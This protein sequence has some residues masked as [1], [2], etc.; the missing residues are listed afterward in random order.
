M[1]K[2]VDLQAINTIRALSIDA[3]EAAN[4]GHPGLPMGA[5]PMA[6]VLWS[7]FLKVNPLTNKSW[8]NRDRF[9]LSAGHGSAM[10]YSLLHLSGY[11]VTLNDLRN[12]R[13]VNSKTPGHPE[14]NHTEGVEATT[15]P[16]GQGVAMAVGMAMAESHLA[17]TYNKPNYPIVDH[18]TY[19]MCGDGDLME[20]V[21]QEACSLAGHLGLGKLI[22]LYDSNDISLD[23]P[24]HK[25][26]TEDTRGKFIAYGWQHLLVEDGNDLDAIYDAINKAKDETDK[27][28]LIEVKTIIGYGASN[29]GTAKVHGAPL[30]DSEAKRVKLLYELNA[31]ESFYVSEDVKKHFHDQMISSGEKA[32]QDWQTL[33]ND[34]EIAY[35]ELSMQYKNAYNNQLP[36]KYEEKLPVFQKG[37]NSASRVTSSEIIQSLAEMI[38]QLW[39]GSADLSSSNHTMIK[40]ADDYTRQSYH[41]RNIWFGVR[42]FAMAAAANGIQLHGGTKVFCGT[43]FVFVDYLKAAIRLSALQKIPTIYVLTHDSIAV[44]EDGPTHEPI[45]QLASLRSIPNVNV[46]RP[47]DANE[48]LFAWKLAIESEHTPTVLVLSRQNLPLIEAKKELIEEGVSKGGYVIS[49]QQGNEPEGILIATGSE[50]SL[51]IEAQ[52]VLS[53]EG[54]DVSVVSLPSFERFNQQPTEYKAHVLPPH[55]EKRVAIEM[56]SSYG[57]HQFVGLKGKICSI[58]SFGASG[59][60]PEIVKMYGFTVD[61]IVHAFKSIG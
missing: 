24:T 40:H 42:E 57:W 59:P 38:P 28:T 19:S 43:F 49:K 8:H 3:V 11:N 58:D 52:N 35:P 1:F 2:R 39:G 33:F 60:G 29:Q 50:V 37:Y 30:G 54:I 15:G 7:K 36:E 18:F 4:S 23:G 27:P 53:R 41:G 25:S 61:N 26:F 14:V 47:A 5:S 6:Y 21:A 32:E 31:E 34:Y 44:G 12:F 51:A 46:F 16:L 9:I 10:L 55:M 45:E 17:A 56:G 13:Q 22:V 20:G 48:T